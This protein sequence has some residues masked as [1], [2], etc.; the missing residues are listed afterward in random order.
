MLDKQQIKEESVSKEE[1]KRLKSERKLAEKLTCGVTKQ[2]VIEDNISLGYLL[3][4][5]HDS[6]DRLWPEII[7]EFIFYDAYV[8]ELQKLGREKL[9]FYEHS[10]FCSVINSSS[11]IY[12]GTTQSIKNYD[13][14]PHMTLSVLITLMNRS[15]VLVFNG[16]MFESKQAMKAYYHLL[17]VLMHFTNIYPELEDKINTTI[18]YFL[19]ELP[20]R[21]KRVVLDIG[22]FLIQIGFNEKLTQ[23]LLDVQI[24][25]FLDTFQSRKVSYHL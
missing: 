9:D 3:L 18:K 4:I 11:V 23:N 2:H 5:K 14:A 20:G 17:H 1:E 22:E 16:E 19:R 25:D 24:E 15:A 10:K 7:L 13:F 12:N 8:A 21:N 6:Y